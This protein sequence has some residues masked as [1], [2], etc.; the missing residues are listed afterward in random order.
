MNDVAVM[1]AVT[2][3]VLTWYGLTR[4]GRKVFK[5]YEDMRM[6]WCPEIGSFSYIET[7]RGKNGSP[8][9]VKRCLLW[10]EYRQCK[11]RCVK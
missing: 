7:A 11:T 5:R 8:V 3:F 9:S 6:V 10:P 2:I 4:I 1:A